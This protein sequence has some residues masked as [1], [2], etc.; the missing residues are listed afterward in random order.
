[1]T[2]K[3]KKKKALIFDIKLN[4]ELKQNEIDE[5][6]S[7]GVD[8]NTARRVITEQWLKSQG[9]L[10][11]VDYESILADPNLFKII[12]E[13]EIP[14][15]VVGELGTIKT[16]FLCSCG[17]LVR[18]A[19]KTSY[20]LMVNDESGVGKDWV[21]EKT[22][23][24]WKMLRF[25]YNTIKRSKGEETFIEKECGIVIKRTRISK[26]VFTYWHNPTFEPDWTWDG[27]IF[28]NEDISN[29]VLNCDVFK[30][31]ASTGSHA[32]VIIDQTPVD[33]EIA[34]KPV[35]I[36]TTASANPKPENIRRFSIVNLDAS[37]N[38]TEEIMKRQCEVAK[39]GKSLQYDQTVMLA[40]KELEIV[41]VKIP[42]ADMIHPVMPTDNI[43]MRT[44]LERF[45]DYIKAS[46]ALYQMQRKR[47][48]DGYVI[49]EPSD[50]DTA[51]EVILKLSSNKTM[52]P[53]TKNQKRLLNII[54]EMGEG[55]HYV[56]DIES[57]VTFLNRN[58]LRENLNKLADCL[59]LVKDK[60]YHEKRK[61]DLMAYSLSSLFDDINIPKFEDIIPKTDTGIHRDTV[62][63]PRDTVVCPKKEAHSAH[64]RVVGA[65]ETTQSLNIPIIPSIPNFLPTK[66][67]KKR[68]NADADDDNRDNRDIGDNRDT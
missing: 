27:K 52:I 18:N 31:M 8:Y 37:I 24:I 6:I 2:K 48:V 16:I 51:R 5:L 63:N 67:D 55:L 65:P 12:T 47:D 3:P 43:I 10:E 53:L 57:K 14:K 59:L 46:A 9:E 25:I 15:K 7:L 32:T 28:Y 61:R 29:S 19:K 45:L 11:N 50:Y 4:K 62:E 68:P 34:G 36:I 39:T 22:L 41:D 38:Q 60:M 26:K 66:S 21:V 20:N 30:V 1:M 13:K 17:R 35:M 58:N 40:L 42:F 44:F 56:N 33:I 64:E 23:E 49:A 54:K